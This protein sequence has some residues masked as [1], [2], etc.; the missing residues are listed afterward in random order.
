MYKLILILFLNSALFATYTNC[1]FQNTNYEDI[2]NSLVKRGVSYEY[3][4]KFLLSPE[5]TKNYDELSWKYL[6]PDK[7]LTYIK[8]EKKANKTLLSHIPKILKHLKKYEQV[9]D[10]TEKKF[11]VNREIVAAI[12][13]K[14]TALGKI[15]LNHDAFKV[16]NTM[17]V[18][19]RLKTPRDKWLMKMGKSSMVSIIQYCYKK[20]LSVDRCNLPSSY[21][22]AV[23]IPQFMPNSFVYA[24][25]YKTKMPD[26]N[27][28]ED[29]IVSA[30]NFL[31]K[32]ASFDKLIEWDKLSNIA[33]IESQWYNYELKYD[34]SSLVYEINK[35]DNTKN[36]CFL[37]N[38]EEHIYLKKYVKKILV[39]NNSSNYAIGVIR[40]AYESYVGL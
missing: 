14:E 10:Y 25:G 29:A 40:L 38:K 20:G 6:H 13:M 9:Y 3:I 17:V 15:K 26:L 23:G 12:L 28:M 39:Y 34:N 16:C 19:N 37:C 24:Q 32:K 35:R 8:N 33:Q 11:G 1:K 27:K 5:K 7:I 22:G 31:N 18:K 21:A 30:S 2:C 36:E 4:N